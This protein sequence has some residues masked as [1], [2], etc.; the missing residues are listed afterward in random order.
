MRADV[1][2]YVTAYCGFCIR[3]KR[4][5]TEKGARFTEI[6]VEGRGDL[7][8]WLRQVSGQHTVPQVFINGRSV[9][10]FTD[11]ASLDEAGELDPLLDEEPD[12]DAA[13]MKMRMPR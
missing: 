8:T 9:G 6:N 7:R 4:L 1:T 13:R 11:V 3:A 2:I 12:G 5:L 10:G